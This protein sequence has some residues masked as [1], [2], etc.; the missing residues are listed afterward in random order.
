MVEV[1]LFSYESGEDEAE[2]LD[3]EADASSDVDS[4]DML[5]SKEQNPRVQ[6]TQRDWYQSFPEFVQ[7]PVET[8]DWDDVSV[9]DENEAP[10]PEEQPHRDF[11]IPDVEGRF[12]ETYRFEVEN[13]GAASYIRVLHGLGH[14]R[15][16]GRLGR[17]LPRHA[18]S[19]A[20]STAI[21]VAVASRPIIQGLAQASVATYHSVSNTV[22]ET[23][24]PAVVDAVNLGRERLPI[25]IADAH[26]QGQELRERLAEGF[27][28]WLE[29]GV[30][31]AT[32]AA[33]RP[34]PERRDAW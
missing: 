14:A 1:P 9:P 28:P 18:L 12:H 34:R 26:F 24:A 19:L 29:L 25:L 17:A 21:D 6:D 2:N 31:Y 22:A 23:V 15:R 27:I 8:D 7:S 10:E 11:E 5:P 13:P 32:S 16:T 33:N 4:W 3:V 20:T 30:E